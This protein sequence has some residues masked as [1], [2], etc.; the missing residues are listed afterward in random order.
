MLAFVKDMGEK[1]MNLRVGALGWAL[2]W[3]FFVLILL[4]R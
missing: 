4:F 2:S 1:K 3:R